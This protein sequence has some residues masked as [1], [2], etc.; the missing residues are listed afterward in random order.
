MET[1][2]LSRERKIG[3]IVNPIAGMGGRVGLRGTDDLV[4]V[5]QEKGAL[6]VAGDRAFRFLVTLKELGSELFEVWSVPGQMGETECTKAGILFK[7]INYHPSDPTTSEDT[8][9]SIQKL[10]QEEMDAIIFVGGDGTARDVMDTWKNNKS[11]KCETAFIGC[12]AGVK[13]Y[14]AIFSTT[15]ESAAE[16]LVTWVKG[17][18]EIVELEIMDADEEAIRQDRFAVQLYGYLPGIFVPLQIQGGKQ[19]SPSTADEQ[20]NQEAIGRTIKEEIAENS[21]FIL[22]P[23]TTVRAVADVLMPNSRKT[24]L[25]VD[26]M[27][28]DELIPDVNEQGILDLLDSGSLNNVKIVVSPIGHQG[29]L[30][31]RGNQQVSPEIIKRIGRDNILV[32]ATRGKL[33]SLENTPFRVDTGD[34]EVDALLEGYIRVLIDYREW[35]MWQIS[36]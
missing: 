23:G 7:L 8:K 11:E 28:G 12:P 25:G 32:V 14:S 24:L 5:A 33:Q 27:T 10:L 1:R 16:V 4:E 17:N 2:K 18:A 31:G 34:A 13:M 9:I 22:G 21:D 15:P 19:V 3:L 36:C 35:R 20:E 6:P 26:V 29:M 30:F